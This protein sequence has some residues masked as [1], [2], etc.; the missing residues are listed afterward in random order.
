MTELVVCPELIREGFDLIQ[1]IDEL[2]NEK[3]II[4]VEYVLPTMD[5]RVKSFLLP[6]G[7]NIMVNRSA[8]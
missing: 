8:I 4:E 3:K 1:L 2:I 6:F 7:T 5:Y